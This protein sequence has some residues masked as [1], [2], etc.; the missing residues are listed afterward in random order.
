MVGHSC[1]KKKSQQEKPPLKNLYI[2]ES[3]AC[4]REELTK[5]A[6]QLRA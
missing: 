5:K 2:A 6:E 1:L 3:P 4:K